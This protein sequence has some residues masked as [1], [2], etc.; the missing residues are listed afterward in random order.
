[1]R[2]RTGRDFTL[3]ELLVV[4][5]IIAI[6]A[7]MLLPALSSAREKAKQITCANKMKQV[8]LIC[9]L[10]AQDWQDWLPVKENKGV[11]GEQSNSIA[12]Q[13]CF[14]HIL[15]T[16]NYLGP[17]TPGVADDPNRRATY[18]R[19]F[20][21][22]ADLGTYPGSSTKGWD[23]SASSMSYYVWLYD[24]GQTPGT[25]ARTSGEPCEPRL[26]LSRDA[27]YR[28]FYFDMYPKYMATADKRYFTHRRT[29]NC[30]NL[31]GSVRS[32]DIN[33]AVNAQT[34]QQR[35]RQTFWDQL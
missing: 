13:L 30:L 24:E 14:T 20:R 27:G 28:V 26:R 3:I 31:G 34:N 5:A 25:C 9:A 2:T 6:L 33:A 29:M 22:P 10:Y 4:I 8:G 23:Y 16:G 17:Y 21:C 32:T 7:S 11:L 12:S 19:L 18:E 35:I 1:M 15:L